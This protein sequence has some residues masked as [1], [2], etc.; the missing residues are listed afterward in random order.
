MGDCRIR[1][2]L[3][4]GWVYISS[5]PKESNKSAQGNALGCL[6]LPKYLSPERSSQPRAPRAYRA[7]PLCSMVFWIVT[8]TQGVG[9]G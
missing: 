8:V 3:G 7:K 4:I 2:I 9:L 5:T 1:P 6:K